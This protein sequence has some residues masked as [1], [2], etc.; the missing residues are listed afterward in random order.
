MPSTI[1]PTALADAIDAHATQLFPQDEWDKQNAIHAQ[2]GIN[3]E[4]NCMMEDVITDVFNSKPELFEGAEWI[5]DCSGLPLW[6]RPGVEWIP[7]HE[8]EDYD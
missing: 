1:N 6:V 7:D 2:R 8:I 4:L 3:F 5:N